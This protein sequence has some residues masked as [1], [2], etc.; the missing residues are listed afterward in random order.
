MKGWFNDQFHSV[1]TKYL[2]S[3]V[4]WQRLLTWFKRDVTPEQFIVSSL[5]R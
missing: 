1:A 2:P 3:Y 5:G 4:A